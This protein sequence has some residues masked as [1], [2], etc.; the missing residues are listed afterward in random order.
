MSASRG[1]LYP[2]LLCFLF[3]H[4][5]DTLFL[6]TA[7]FSIS[8]LSFAKF[9]FQSFSSRPDIKTETGTH[10]FH[11]T[12]ILTPTSVYKHRKRPCSWNVQYINVDTER[13]SVWSEPKDREQ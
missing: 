9:F 6:L 11:L 1:H 13:S 10:F 4:A 2:C 7:L 8:A 12:S 3:V 5:S